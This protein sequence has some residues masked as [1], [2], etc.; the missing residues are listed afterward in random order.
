ML[1]MVLESSTATREV[2]SFNEESHAAYT[3]VRYLFVAHHERWITTLVTAG[4]VI[5]MWLR[6]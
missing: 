5:A 4:I 3:A 1:L 2:P 6:V